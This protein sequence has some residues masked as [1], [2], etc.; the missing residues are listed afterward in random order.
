MATLERTNDVHPNVVGKHIFFV[1]S[2]F[3]SDEIK[4]QIKVSIVLL[5]RKLGKD[6]KKDILFI[7]EK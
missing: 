7:Y 6:L 5:P 4:S 3:K 2:R 1:I